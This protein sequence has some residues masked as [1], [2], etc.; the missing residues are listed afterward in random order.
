MKGTIRAAKGWL[1][2]FELTVD[3][4]AQPAPSSRDALTFGAPRNGA[5]SKCDI[6]LD[7]VRRRF[8]VSRRRSARWLSARRSGRSGRDAARGDEGARSDRHLRQAALHHLRRRDLRAFAFANRRLPPLPRSLPDRR[9]HAG[10]RSCR[11]QRGNLRRMRAM[12][13]GLPDRRCR[14]CIAA[15]RRADAQAAHAAADLSRSRR[16]QCGAVA[17]R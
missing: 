17:P 1:G 15:G 7:L 12:R 14:L 5:V 16:P 3:D 11:D 4:Y 10:R 2:A 9:D 13:R 6:V 8:A